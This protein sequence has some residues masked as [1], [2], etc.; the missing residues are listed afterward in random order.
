MLSFGSLL[1]KSYRTL[2]F[3]E[4]PGIGFVVK[5]AWVNRPPHRPQTA[6]DMTATAAAVAQLLKHPVPEVLRPSPDCLPLHTESFPQV[7]AIIGENL[8]KNWKPSTNNSKL[9]KHVLVRTPI[10]NPEYK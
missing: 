10:R 1:L 4:A 7:F 5:L 6:E 9:G 2:F 3:R 8:G